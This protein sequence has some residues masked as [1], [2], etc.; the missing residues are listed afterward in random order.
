MSL[1]P[2]YCRAADHGAEGDARRDIAGSGA[3]VPFESGTKSFYPDA[4]FDISNSWKSAIATAFER[5]D[6]SGNR[7]SVG[8]TSTGE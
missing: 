6:Q 5:M 3:R 8:K 2:P 7:E 1:D 4:V